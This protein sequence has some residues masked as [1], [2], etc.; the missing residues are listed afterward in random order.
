MSGDE[1]EKNHKEEKAAVDGEAQVE[2]PVVAS[3]LGD[4][5]EAADGGEGEGGGDLETW[6]ED[7]SEP[8]ISL[9]RYLSKR[10]SAPRMGWAQIFSMVM[11]L[12]GLI[13]IMVY[14]DSCGRQVSEV[15]G[16]MNTADAGLPG[17]PVRVRLAPKKKPVA[18]KFQDRAP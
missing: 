3:V 5:G 7:S 2:D 1:H 12:V 15:M 18:P 14:K 10:H 6:P 4:E 13:L 17:V 11:M 16:A 8:Q 9:D